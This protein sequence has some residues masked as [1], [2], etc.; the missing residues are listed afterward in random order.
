M[1]ARRLSSA[2]PP[3][4]LHRA[5]AILRVCAYGPARTW[6]WVNEGAIMRCTLRGARLIDAAL[7]IPAGD[8]TFTSERIEAVGTTATDVDPQSAVDAGGLLVVPG[9]V[10]VHTHGGGGFNLHTT[11]AAEIQGYAHW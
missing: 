9:F 3:N 6:P 4:S 11:D 5:V 10:D 8:I 7:D 2:R 1:G